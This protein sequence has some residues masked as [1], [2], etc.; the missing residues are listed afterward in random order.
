MTICFDLLKNPRVAQIRMDG[1][2]ML[3]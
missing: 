3:T 1:H 2:G